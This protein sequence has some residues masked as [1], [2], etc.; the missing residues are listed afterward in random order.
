MYEGYTPPNEILNLE[1]PGNGSSRRWRPGLSAFLEAEDVTQ[2]EVDEVR[3][4]L[5]ELGSDVEG[6]DALVRAR[7]V[8]AIES[9]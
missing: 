9:Q 1:D 7:L 8:Q 6:D 3:E 2:L 4:A 5:E